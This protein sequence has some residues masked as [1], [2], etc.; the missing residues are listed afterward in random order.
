L[1]L[2]Y[3]PIFGTAAEDTR[4]LYGMRVVTR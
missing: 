3:R 1:A 4:Y 2:T